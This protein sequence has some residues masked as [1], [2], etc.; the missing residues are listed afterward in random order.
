MALTANMPVGTQH[1]DVPDC[2]M[3]GDHLCMLEEIRD[4]RMG[5][6]WETLQLPRCMFGVPASSVRRVQL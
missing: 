4:P 6:P 3:C 5:K 2:M 1:S